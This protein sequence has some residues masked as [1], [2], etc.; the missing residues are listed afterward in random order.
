MDRAKRQNPATVA[1]LPSIQVAKCIGCNCTDIAAC[2][3]IIGP[4]FW[5]KVDY[6][7][8]IGVCSECEHKIEEYKTRINRL[9]GVA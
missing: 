2:D 5:I 4:C 3:T 8:G 7:A 1:M 9:N 6:K